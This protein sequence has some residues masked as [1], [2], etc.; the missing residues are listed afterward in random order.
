MSRK[1]DKHSNSDDATLFRDS[2]GNVKPV[3]TRRQRLESAAPKPRARFSRQDDQ[4]VLIESMTDGPD[5]AAMETG[6]ELVFHR[7]N[8]GRKIMRQLRRGNYVVQAEIDLH[9]LTAGEAQAELHDFI[10]ECSGQGLKCIRVVQ[11]PIL[12]AGVNRWLTHWQ[13]VTAFCSAQPRDGG[14]GAVYVLLVKT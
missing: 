13:E 11:G 12:K 3:S 8:V 14:T 7:P 4:A 6:E 9:G 2:I 1:K 10:K 5:S